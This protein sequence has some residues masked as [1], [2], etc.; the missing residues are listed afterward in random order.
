MDGTQ[1]HTH[2]KFS[3]NRITIGLINKMGRP[4]Y[5]YTS[6]KRKFVMF[7]SSE[8]LG[9]EEYIKSNLELGSNS[10]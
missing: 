8:M 2:C 5:E 7:Q 3:S 6:I 9:I 4:I 1:K 10:W